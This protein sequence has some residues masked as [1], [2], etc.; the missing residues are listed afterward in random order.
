MLETIRDIAIILVAILDIVILALLAAIAF[1]LFRLFLKVKAYVPD[2]LDTT[3][4]TLTQVKGTTDFVTDTA[5]TPLI[6]AVSRFFA[7]LFGGQRRR[8]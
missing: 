3:K 4:S 6:A 2:V 8:I 1:I 7:V 5:V